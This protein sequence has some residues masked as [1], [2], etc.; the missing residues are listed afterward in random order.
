MIGHQH[1]PFVCLTATQSRVTY[2]EKLRDM[3]I[4]SIAFHRIDRP[5]LQY[6]VDLLSRICKVDLY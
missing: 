1:R 2:I 5:E 6:D 3:T 4:I